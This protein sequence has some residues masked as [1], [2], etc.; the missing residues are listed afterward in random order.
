MAL[1]QISTGAYHGCGIGPAGRLYCWGDNAYGQLGD[2]SMTP[3]TT[4]VQVGLAT[5]W[6]SVSAGRYHTCGIRAGALYCWG[7]T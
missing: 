7:T 5:N 3:R 6:S 1:A 4:P 2:G